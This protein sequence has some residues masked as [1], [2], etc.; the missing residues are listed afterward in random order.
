VALSSEDSLSS[1]PEASPL[2]DV[3]RSRRTAALK[4]EG[5]VALSLI[6][7]QLEERLGVRL[8]TR[9]KR[10]VSLTKAGR[11]LQHSRELRGSKPNSRR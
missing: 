6:I 4:G 8:V 9:T 5:S 2:S 10:R 11:R 1:F 7:R 3:A